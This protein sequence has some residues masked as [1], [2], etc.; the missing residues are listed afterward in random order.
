MVPRKKTVAMT[1]RGHQGALPPQA[2]LSASGQSSAESG[3]RRQTQS[4]GKAL[5]PSSCPFLPCGAHRAG[6]KGA[7]NLRAALGSRARRGPGRGALRALAP[8]ASPSFLRSRTAASLRSSRETGERPPGVRH[9]LGPAGAGRPGFRF[10]RGG[11]E[12]VPRLLPRCRRLHLC[13]EPRT[14]P[15]DRMVLQSAQTCLWEE[16]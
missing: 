4:P 12:V 10:W 1:A 11:A 6:R 3:R 15:V 2:C 14:H 13:L 16:G 5:S 7:R 8:P 9:F